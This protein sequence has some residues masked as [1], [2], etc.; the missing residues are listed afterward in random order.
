MIWR[1]QSFGSLPYITKHVPCLLS[2]YGKGYLIPR[3]SQNMCR[4]LFPLHRRLHVEPVSSTI[5]GAGTFNFLPFF[6]SSRN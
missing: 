2:T 5:R 1:Q 4:L 3:L 6:H